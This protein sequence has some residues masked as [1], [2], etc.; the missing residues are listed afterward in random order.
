MISFAEVA[1]NFNYVKPELTEDK[2]MF[3][4]RSRHPLAELNLD[5]FVA[6]DY[7]SSNSS[8]RVKIITGPNSCGKSVYL[9]QVAIIAY[10][11]HIGSYVPAKS[12]TISMLNSIHTRMNS[13]ESTAFKHSAFMND[14]RQ[15]KVS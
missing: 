14:L 3:I 6:N 11:A 15:V 4:E 9:K 8:N 10:M 12:A 2:D 7:A 1:D 13:C 5:N